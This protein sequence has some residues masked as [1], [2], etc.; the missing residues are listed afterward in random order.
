VSLGVV[1][2]VATAGFVAHVV[3]ATEKIRKRIDQY[4]FI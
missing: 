2:D 4:D 3:S 1:L